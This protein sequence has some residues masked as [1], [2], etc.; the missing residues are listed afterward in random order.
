[1]NFKGIRERVKLDFRPITLLFGANSAG[2]S[3]VLHALHYA[4]EVFERHNLDADQTIAGGKYID[5][6]GFEHF[7]NR[8]DHDEV[9]HAQKQLRLRI[10]VALTAKDLPSFDANFDLMSEQLDLEFHSLLNEIKSAA[11]EVAIGWS[12]VEHCPYVASTTIFYNDLALAQIVTPQNLRG[13]V[14]KFTRVVPD[15]NDSENFVEDS[16]LDHPCL[17]RVGD[18][19][20]GEGQ[21]TV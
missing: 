3:T 21:I 11:V 10:E 20:R 1:E 2:K 15:P 5:L 4:R 8:R 16:T 14:L 17:K 12:T 13:F 7:V 19:R 6:G 18:T 9:L